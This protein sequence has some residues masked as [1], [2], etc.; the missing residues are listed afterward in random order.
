M[1]KQ[2]GK[3]IKKILITIYFVKF[4]FVTASGHTLASA[5]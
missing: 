3:I 1:K 2:L 5:L 4:A